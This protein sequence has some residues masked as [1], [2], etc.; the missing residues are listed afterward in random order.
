VTDRSGLV[1]RVHV[2]F[3]RLMQHLSETHSD[4][5][6]ELDV[7]MPQ[8]KLLYLLAAAGEIHMSALAARL[9]VTL[10]TVSGAVDRLVARGLASR[11]DDPADRRQVVV[12][13][14]PEGI[15]LVERFRELNDAQLSTLLDALDDGQL[16]VVAD[17]VEILAAAAATSAAPIQPTAIAQ[18]DRP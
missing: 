16:G 4:E 3:E 9:R 6:V 12:A 17:A 14:T 13:A 7:S 2:G 1:A 11:H 10:S 5:F 8:A 15:A 18:V